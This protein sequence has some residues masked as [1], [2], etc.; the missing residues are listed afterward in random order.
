MGSHSLLQGIFPT[1]GS[2]PDL[3]H[4]REI[5][6]H[7]SH[8]GSP[9]I[10]DCCFLL[11]GIFPTQGSNSCL[12]RCQAKSF[13]LSHLG[14]PCLYLKAVMIL[15]GCK[16]RGG[17]CACPQE[18]A[19]LGQEV[20]LHGSNSRKTGWQIMPPRLCSEVWSWS[21]LL[22]PSI[23]DASR[24]CLVIAVDLTLNST[25][26]CRQITGEHYILPAE[27]GAHGKW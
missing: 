16:K 2:N 24:G 8:W 22:F 27:A 26:Q 3:L 21:V 14:S 11:Q 9:K 17:C 13:P 15:Q 5:L 25:W 6:S 4:C 23:S 18:A 20:G 12:L 7:L 10:T 19:R 1:Q